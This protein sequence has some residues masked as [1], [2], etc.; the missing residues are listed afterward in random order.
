MKKKLL[1]CTILLSISAGAFAIKEKN[2]DGKKDQS[3]SEI[4][5]IEEK[6]LPLTKSQQDPSGSLGS[7]VDKD[8]EEKETKVIKQSWLR[9]FFYNWTIGLFISS[10]TLEEKVAPADTTGKNDVTPDEKK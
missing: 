10:K 7:L 8:D 4:I 6:K 3:L 9:Q 1:L 5:T 2:K